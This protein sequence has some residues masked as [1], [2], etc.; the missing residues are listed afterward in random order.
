VYGTY[1]AIPNLIFEI[2]LAIDQKLVCA[3]QTR[4]GVLQ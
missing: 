4:V 1:D 3:T 2:K